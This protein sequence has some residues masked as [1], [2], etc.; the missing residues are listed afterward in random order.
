MIFS[1]VVQQTSINGLYVDDFFTQPVHLK[2]AKNCK[3]S[4][5]KIGRQNLDF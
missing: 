2:I 5:L 4:N 3:I 1:Y